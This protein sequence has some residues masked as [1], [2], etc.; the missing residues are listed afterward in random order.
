MPRKGVSGHEGRREA[1]SAVPTFQPWHS[2][3]LQCSSC[4]LNIVY[5]LDLR[6]CY[7]KGW[8][9]HATGG[10]WPVGG[11]TSRQPAESLEPLHLGLFGDLQRIVNFD[12]EVAHRALQF[13]MAEQQLHH[14]EILCSSVDQ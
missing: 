13:G 8:R 11:Q 1:L 4:L 6:D 12:S 5:P 10:S 7:G 14:S 9:P 3:A 2:L